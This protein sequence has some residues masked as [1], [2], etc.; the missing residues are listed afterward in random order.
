[1]NERQD[2]FG[3]DRLLEVLHSQNGASA[4][5]M[6]DRVFG[7]LRSFRGKYP[8]HDDTTLVILRAGDG[9]T[10]EVQSIQESTRTL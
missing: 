5:T 8:S 6:L 10:P 1:M 4:D 2:E 3:E 7:S 9:G